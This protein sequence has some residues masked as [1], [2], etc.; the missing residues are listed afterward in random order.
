MGIVD[1]I[2]G[3]LGGGGGDDA[4][5]SSLFDQAKGFL[6]NNGLDGLL[7][8]LNAGGVG[9]K[10]SNWVSTGPN[11]EMTADEVGKAFS[12]DELKEVA[13]KAGISEDE[14]KTGLAAMIPSLIDKLTPDGNVPGKDQLGGLLD[15]IPGIGG[16]FK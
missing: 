8:R 14:A 11:P 10:A 9:D 12:D 3:L 13:E 6:G 1:S 15:S 2:K 4:G 5:L 7:D 16:L